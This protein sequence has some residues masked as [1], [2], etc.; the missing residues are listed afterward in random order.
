MAE[1]VITIEQYSDGMMD[2][3]EHNNN[4]RRQRWNYLMYWKWSS[5]WLFW[6]IQSIHMNNVI[7]KSSMNHFFSPW[8][9]YS[10]WAYEMAGAE[11]IKVTAIPV[12]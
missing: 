12:E 8:I 3:D 11:Y 5:G 4:T 9:T 7:I 6:R 1:G 2:H 10:R